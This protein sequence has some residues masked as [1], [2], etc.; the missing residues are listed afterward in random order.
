MRFVTSF[1][2]IF[3]NLTGKSEAV[4]ELIN[5]VILDK[6]KILRTKCYIK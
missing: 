3:C 6:T 1:C 2:Y 4:R 5:Y